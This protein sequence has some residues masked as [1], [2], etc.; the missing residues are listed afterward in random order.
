MGRTVRRAAKDA[1]PHAHALIVQL[2]AGALLGIAQLCEGLIKMSSPNGAV[3]PAVIVLMP[4]TLMPVGLANEAA[5]RLR[6][7]AT[8]C[9]EVLEF[10]SM[11]R[12]Q[13]EF[14]WYLPDLP[15]PLPAYRRCAARCQAH[16]CRR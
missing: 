12:E 7:A 8:V 15:R 2:G 13:L 5:V 10:L 11:R 14:G 9:A 4:W 1:R 6:I 16:S 3:P